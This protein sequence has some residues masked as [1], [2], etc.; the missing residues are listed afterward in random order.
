[1][2]LVIPAPADTLHRYL[3]PYET[4][5]V[6]TLLEMFIVAVLSFFLSSIWRSDE[7]N[8]FL[9]MRGLGEHTKK[10]L[11]VLIRDTVGLTQPKRAAQTWHVLKYSSHEEV[12]ILIDHT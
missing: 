11:L 9:F 2:K 6:A 5:T 1:M 7:M 10:F 3:P 12:F 4:G 8:I